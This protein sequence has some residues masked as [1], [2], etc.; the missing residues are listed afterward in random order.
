MDGRGCIV[1]GITFEIPICIESDGDG[2]YAYCP[3]L[4]GVHVGGETKEEALENV[5]TASILYIKSLIDHNDP[6][7][8]QLVNHND[9]KNDKLNTHCSHPVQLEQVF[10]NA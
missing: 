1:H 6:I 7:P 9:T 10:V 4:K 2:Y 5:K 3:V 8:L